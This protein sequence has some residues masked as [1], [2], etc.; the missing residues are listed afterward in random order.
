VI[1]AG[2]DN[3]PGG[4]SLVVAVVDLHF[5]PV[6]GFI[7]SKKYGFGF[8]IVRQDA[9]SVVV[10]ASGAIDTI[11]NVFCFVYMID[12]IAV[13]AGEIVIFVTICAQGYVISIGGDAILAE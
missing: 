12:F 8:S 5:Y 2:F 13:F 4:V 7:V 6:A 10:G 11:T 1:P 9:G 3:I